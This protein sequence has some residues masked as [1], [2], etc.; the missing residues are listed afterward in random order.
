MNPWL[1]FLALGVL[2]FAADAATRQA[3]TPVLPG[4]DATASDRDLLLAHAIAR[5]DHRTDGVVRRRLAMNLRFATGDEE[6]TDAELV[7][8]A[9]ALGMHQSDLVVRRRLAQRLALEVKATAR[10]GEP[11]ESE[12]RA[13]LE[14]HGDRFSEPARYHLRQLP[15]AD[16]EQAEVLLASLPPDPEAAVGHGIALVLPRHLPSHSERELASLFGP[17][18][19]AAVAQQPVGRWSGPVSSPY[20]VHLVFVEARDPSRRSALRVV[21]AQLREALLE[22]RAEAALRATLDAWRREAAS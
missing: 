22:E 15:L 10:V 19:A 1:R 14:A 9:I 21:R 4:V 20:A 16:A 2:L 18:F 13:S 8:R 7:D 11:S 3:P 6:A 17:G 12:L 5:G